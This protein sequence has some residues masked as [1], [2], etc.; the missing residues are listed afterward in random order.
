MAET[1]ETKAVSL[2]RGYFASLTGKNVDGVVK[3]FNEK[4]QVVVKAN[5]YEEGKP[6]Q[7]E[8]V[9]N[10]VADIRSQ[11]EQLFQEQAQVVR[12]VDVYKAS[13][14]SDTETEVYVRYGD[15]GSNFEVTYTVD[16]E[17]QQFTK[18][19]VVKIAENTRKSSVVA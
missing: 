19:E 10:G 14:A 15:G 4:Y 8:L 12:M 3:C 11:H 13:W 9:A 18:R 2:L 7:D 16:N 17:A 5:A 6:A 1:W